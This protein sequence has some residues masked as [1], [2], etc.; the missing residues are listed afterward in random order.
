[1]EFG[2]HPW[3]ASSERGVMHEKNDYNSLVPGRRGNN[4]DTVIFIFKLS[5]EFFGTSWEIALMCMPRINID[6]GNG[7]VT[8]GNKTLHET[9]LVQI[10]PSYDC[11]NIYILCLTII[12]KSEV[13]TIKPLFRV[14]SWNNGMRCMSFYILT[15]PDNEFNKNKQNAYI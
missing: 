15:S 8:S 5:I 10:Y 9:M 4:F 7:L 6:A 2:T 3:S 1:M 14:R 13:W 12:I 11:E